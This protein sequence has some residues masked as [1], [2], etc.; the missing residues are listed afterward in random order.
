MEAARFPHAL[1][2]GLCGSCQVSTRAH[3]RTPWKLPCFHTTSPWD[4]MDAVLRFTHTNV[5]DKNRY[6][7]SI[8]HVSRTDQNCAVLKRAEHIMRHVEMWSVVRQKQT[9]RGSRKMCS[10]LKDS[11][12]KSCKF[13]S[14]V[15]HHKQR[16]LLGCG[17]SDQ[18]RL[19]FSLSG[20]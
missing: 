3:H 5:A 1:S 19:T 13:I 11:F 7:T 12:T 2:L 6:Y 17:R 20:S 4:S 8:H 14:R 18:S 15:K 9:V 10:R 16:S